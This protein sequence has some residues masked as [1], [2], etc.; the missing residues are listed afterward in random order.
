MSNGTCVP[1]A[2]P[3]ASMILL[4]VGNAM[5]A[6]MVGHWILLSMYL[7]HLFMALHQPWI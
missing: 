1:L 7:Y 3:L 6:K 2:I 4:L 5:L